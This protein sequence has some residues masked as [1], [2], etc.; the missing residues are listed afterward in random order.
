MLMQAYDNGKGAV[1]TESIYLPF[2]PLVLEPWN[3]AYVEPS[4]RPADGRY[5]ETQTVFTNNYH[6]KW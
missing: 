2:V 5:G 1:S 3:A 4:R 6:P